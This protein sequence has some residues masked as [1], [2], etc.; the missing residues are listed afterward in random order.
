MKHSLLT[1]PT[2][3][4]WQRSDTHCTGGEYSSPMRPHG[5]Y[6]PQGFLPQ[7][8]TDVPSKFTAFP[9]FP[10]HHHSRLRRRRASVSHGNAAAGQS[11]R[12]VCIHILAL[13]L[14]YFKH[15]DLQRHFVP[16]IG[17]SNPQDTYQAVKPTSRKTRVNPSL[18]KTCV[19][20]PHP[21][22]PRDPCQPRRTTRARIA[23][24]S[25]PRAPG[26]SNSSVHARYIGHP[27]VYI[28]VLLL[29]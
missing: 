9:R 29:Q 2:G 22:H 5:N 20:L 12:S 28:H 25:D 27:R 15:P 8:L 21:P 13:P 10:S 24:A 3:P 23:F 6:L 11:V 16:S 17:A 4:T 18:H 19:D 1:I 26:E 14:P 7:V